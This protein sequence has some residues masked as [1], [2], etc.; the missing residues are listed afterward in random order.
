MASL[1]PPKDENITE[2][3]DAAEINLQRANQIKSQNNTGHLQ[4]DRIGDEESTFK[5]IIFMNSPWL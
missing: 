4:T 5:I 3:I 2:W 1:Q